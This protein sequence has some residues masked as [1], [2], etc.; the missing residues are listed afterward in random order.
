MNVDDSKL[1]YNSS[2]E[3]DQLVKTD[4][5]SVGSGL[6]AVFNYSSLGVSVNPEYEVYFKPSGDTKWYKDGAFSTNGSYFTTGS[7]F[8]SYTD[9][10]SIFI[11]TLT[12]GTARYY[13]WQ[14][15]IDY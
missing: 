1:A 2:W 10:T 14:D 13:I 12:A 6:S 3:I 5:V 9:G 11:N 15:K 4:D 7:Q 8:F